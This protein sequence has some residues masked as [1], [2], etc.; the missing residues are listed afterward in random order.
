MLKTK[1]DKVKDKKRELKQGFWDIAHFLN[2][3]LTTCNAVLPE[4]RTELDAALKGVNEERME[5]VKIMQAASRSEQQHRSELEKARAILTAQAQSFFKTWLYIFKHE[6]RPR[7]G[8][9][10]PTSSSPR[11]TTPR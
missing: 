7:Q 11:R 10:T 8:P 2:A 1:L 9:A 3:S 4:L 6:N 5:W